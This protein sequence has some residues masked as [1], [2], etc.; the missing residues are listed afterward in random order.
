M[1]LS[2]KQIVRESIDVLIMNKIPVLAFVFVLAAS[3]IM[4][5]LFGTQDGYTASVEPAVKTAFEDGTIAPADVYV[6]D[7]GYSEDEDLVV[8]EVPAHGNVIWDQ[9]DSAVST[10][11]MFAFIF[12]ALYFARKNSK[13]GDSYT[14]KEIVY[15]VLTTFVVLL[16]MAIGLVLLIIPGIYAIV[17]F[18]FA[19]Y[20]SLDYGIS[21]IKAM[22]MSR[23]AV[24]G[25]FW[26]VFWIAFLPV[27]LIIGVLLALFAYAVALIFVPEQ[28]VL[29]LMP[30]GIVCAFVMMSLVGLVGIQMSAQAHVKLDVRKEES[31]E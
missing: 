16:V 8:L 2:I 10:T 26:K 17:V 14:T 27:V 31:G 4:V 18:F 5:T 1:K 22:K 9:I 15:T 12:V 7:R 13:K 20:Y 21:P 3:G 25:N 29:V 24:Q 6:W 30:L 11:L 19:P 23:E 28:A